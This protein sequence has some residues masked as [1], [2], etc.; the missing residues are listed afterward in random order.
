MF[1]MKKD[2]FMDSSLNKNSKIKVLLKR[3]IETIKYFD[4]KYLKNIKFI[5]H[6]IYFSLIVAI[7]FYGY[8]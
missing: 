8:I 2:N 6:F 5:E 4:K 3:L 1:N 7:F